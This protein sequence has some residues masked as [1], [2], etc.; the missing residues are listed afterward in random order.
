MASK[1]ENTKQM[2]K[3]KH[4]FTQRQPKLSLTI[5][6]TFTAF[7]WCSRIYCRSAIMD[8]I[9]EVIA[10]CTFICFNFYRQRSASSHI[11]SITARPAV[12]CGLKTLLGDQGCIFIGWCH[13]CVKKF[14]VRQN[15]VAGSCPVVMKSSIHSG[16]THITWLLRLYSNPVGEPEPPR[17][18]PPTPPKKTLHTYTHTKLTHTLLSNGNKTLAVIWGLFVIFSGALSGRHSDISVSAQ[19]PPSGVTHN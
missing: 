12:P 15:T 5:T 3:A 4:V 10:Q 17:P 13:A 19:K 1:T 8:C 9:N 14:D 2:P 16:E 11:S 6:F 7:Q 18:Q